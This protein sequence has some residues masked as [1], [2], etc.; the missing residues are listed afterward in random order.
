MEENIKQVII[1]RKDLKMPKGKMVAQGSH[2]SLGAILETMRRKKLNENSYELI[3]D[4]EKHSDL[5]VWI[6]GIFKKVCLYVNS[7]SELT[8]IYNKAMEMK[9]PAYMTVDLGLT[10]FNGVKQ[11]TAVA[12]GPAKGDK[13]DEITGNLKL[14]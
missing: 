10:V 14:L 1:I 4:I 3:L 12:I 6:N 8:N 11:K 7:E 2:A 9:L 5:D 13:I